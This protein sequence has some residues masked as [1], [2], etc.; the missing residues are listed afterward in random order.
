VNVR[1][2]R[3]SVQTAPAIERR[4]TR[5]GVGRDAQSLYI[6]TTFARVASAPDA[7]LRSFGVTLDWIRD[8]RFR[9]RREQHAGRVNVR[10]RRASVQTAPAID[11]GEHI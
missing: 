9:R 5:A 4:G 2:R 6:V 11:E 3:A 10:R 8:P 7:N 1:R